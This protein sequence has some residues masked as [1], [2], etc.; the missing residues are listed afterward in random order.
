[1]LV[2]NTV[3]Y[4]ESLEPVTFFSPDYIKHIRLLINY[5]TANKL[6]EHFENFAI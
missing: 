5:G 4:P 1:M 3:L 2:T 6:W